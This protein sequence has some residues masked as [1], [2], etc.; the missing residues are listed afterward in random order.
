MPTVPPASYIDEH[1]EWGKNFTP[2]DMTGRIITARVMLDAVD[3]GASPGIQAFFVLKT[4]TAAD[5]NAFVYANGAFT[6]LSAGNWVTVIMLADSP[7]FASTGFDPSRVRQV[8]VGIQGNTND[9]GLTTA[10]IHIDSVGYQ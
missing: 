10:S 1:V 9:T 7:G 5:P 8:A 3:G 4:A 2:T 6:G